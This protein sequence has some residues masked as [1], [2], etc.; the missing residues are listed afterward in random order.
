MWRDLCEE[1]FECYRQASTAGDV[2]S[3]AVALLR[4]LDLP[5]KHLH[6]Q[7]VSTHVRR[8]LKRQQ[9][10]RNDW[11]AQRLRG[12]LQRIALEEAAKWAFEDGL[13]PQVNHVQAP[14]SDSDDSEANDDNSSEPPVDFDVP[15]DCTTD[16]VQAIQRARR[17]AAAGHLNMASRAVCSNNRTLDCND[18]SVMQQLRRMHPSPLAPFLPPFDHTSPPL[19]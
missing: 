10:S 11:Q 13:P 18:P 12:Q 15:D 2:N 14:R 9:R 8:M 7:R 3:A 4:I 6:K 17:L 5:A 19:D 1:A 16:D